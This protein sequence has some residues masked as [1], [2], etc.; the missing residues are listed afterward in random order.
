MYI[1]IG[2]LNVEITSTRKK[3]RVSDGFEP[4]TLRDLTGRYSH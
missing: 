3:I 2:I 1:I 4:M